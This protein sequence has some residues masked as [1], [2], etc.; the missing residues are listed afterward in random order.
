MGLVS[1]FAIAGP[2]Y[3]HV[4]QLTGSWSG[5]ARETMA[6]RSPLGMMSQILHVNWMSGV[7]SIVLL[8]IWFGAWSFLRLP[9]LWYAL[10]GMIFAFASLGVLAGFYTRV[11]MKYSVTL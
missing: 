3:W 5:L 2:W 7:K 1:I 8:H 4:H 11:N 9:D 10:F 6:S